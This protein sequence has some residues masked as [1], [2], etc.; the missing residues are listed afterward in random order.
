MRS[1]ARPLTSEERTLIAYLWG[2]GAAHNALPAGILV[3]QMD[4]GGMGSLS[5]V[6]AKRHRAFGGVAGSCFFNDSDGVRV[7]ASLMLDRE[8]DLFELE[9]WKVDFYPLIRIPSAGCFSPVETEA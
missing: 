2:M 1:T 7:E 4:D 6:S 5:F 9:M 3:E 8:G